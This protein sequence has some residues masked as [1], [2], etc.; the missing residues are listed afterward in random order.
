MSGD[1][2]TPKE[3]R[4]LELIARGYTR[5]Q[6][7]R[8]LGVATATV[9]NHLDR[10]GKRLGRNGGAAYIVGEAYRRGW[11]P[12][13]E[14][15]APLVDVPWQ[16]KQ[17]KPPKPDLKGVE[18]RERVVAAGLVPERTPQEWADHPT[19]LFDLIRVLGGTSLHSIVA[20]RRKARGKAA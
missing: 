16:T 9:S 13:G 17:P 18:A 5:P 8:R 7:A 15:L 12:V 19:A 10:I 20:E 14:P 11:L 1:Q 6:A 4:V 2:L 3:M